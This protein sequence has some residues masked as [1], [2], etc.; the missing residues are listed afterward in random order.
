M[1]INRIIKII[2][3]GVA[4]GV[5]IASIAFGDTNNT[6][7]DLNVIKQIESGGNPKAYNKRS[8][9]MGLY[10][11]TPVCLQDYNQCH[12]QNTI[13]REGLYDP[14]KNYQVANWYFNERIVH[15]LNNYKIPDTVEHRII[16]YNAGI[17]CGIKHYREN[18]ALP[19]E[20]INYIKKYNKLTE[21]HI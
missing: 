2:F 4:T 17:G 11:I 3:F 20:T 16:A 1:P 14:N 18:K 5:L 19:Q 6:H 13:T 10:Q 7:I 21:G 12:P 9:A 8:Q 15:F